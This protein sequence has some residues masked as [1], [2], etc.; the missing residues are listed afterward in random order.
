MRVVSQDNGTDIPF[1]NTVFTVK[2]ESNNDYSVY[3]I[4]PQLGNYK[5]AT[6]SF[7]YLAKLSLEEMRNSQFTYQVLHNNKSPLF[8][9]NKMD[10]LFYHFP[11]NQEYLYKIKEELTNP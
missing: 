1:E 10:A 9:I 2:K 4:V 6:Y 11:S 8:A 7:E 5:M 3:A